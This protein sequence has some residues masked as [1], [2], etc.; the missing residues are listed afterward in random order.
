MHFSKNAFFEITFVGHA[1][2]R[3]AGPRRRGG[4]RGAGG[5]ARRGGRGVR[6]GARPARCDGANLEDLTEKEDLNSAR[7][8]DSDILEGY[9]RVAD[10]RKLYHEISLLIRVISRLTVFGIEK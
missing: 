5:R 2:R 10:F 7:R 8:V 4:L 1:G 3:G 9:K 6:R